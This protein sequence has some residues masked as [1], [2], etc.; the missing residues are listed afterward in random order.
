MIM[1][2]SNAELASDLEFVERFGEQAMDRRYETQLVVRIPGR[3]S[4]AS[5]RDAN[6]NRRQFACRAVNI[7]QS[8]IMLAASVKGPIGE[9]VIS[10]FEEF[11]KIQGP[12]VRVLDL[13]FVVKITA[14]DDDRSKLLR[15]L[16]W[17]E[18]NK[19][20]DVPDVRAH[21]RVIPQDPISTLIFA[22][23]STLGCFVID[24][25]ESGVAVSAD[26]IPEVKTVLAVGRVVGTVVRHFT[27]GFAVRFNKAQNSSILEELVI[28]KC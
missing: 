28:R 14:N 15:K 22:D 2:G 12:I 9:R 6:G 7:S 18:Q 27:E 3:F 24:M 23:G 8:S 21:A 25:S 19:N 26:I 11:G 17:L 20:W 5:R 16:L 13:G 10:Y 1:S 4:L